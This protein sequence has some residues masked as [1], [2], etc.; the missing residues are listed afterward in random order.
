MDL[1]LCPSWRGSLDEI[2]NLDEWIARSSAILLF[3]SDKYFTS[4][5][6]NFEQWTRKQKRK[7]VLS[8]WQMCFNKAHAACIMLSQLQSIEVKVQYFGR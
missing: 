8:L 5:N 2:N 4:K 1:N 7:H 6:L 3:A